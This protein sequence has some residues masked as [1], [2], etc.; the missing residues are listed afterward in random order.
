MTQLRFFPARALRSALR[1]VQS[2]YIDGQLRRAGLGRARAI[3]TFTSRTELEALFQIARS[4]EAN[5]TIVEIGSYLGASTCYLAAG[6]QPQGGRIVCIDTWENQTMPDGVRDTYKEF[7]DHLRPVSNMIE[8]VRARSDALRPDHLP[9]S[10]DLAFIDGDHSYAASA[11]DF[12]LVCDR[13]KSGGTVVF[14]DT[15]HFQGPSRVLGEA[16]ARGEWKLGGRV[17]NLAWIQKSP[18]AK[19]D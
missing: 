16:L 2:A 13:V 17:E 10:I 6:V 15:E 7:S 3:H 19:N 5:A 4:L 18:F 1:R 12:S 14:H 8:T 11:G 9:A